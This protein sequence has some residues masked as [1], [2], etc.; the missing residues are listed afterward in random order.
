ML[1]FLNGTG[2]VIKFIVKY[3]KRLIDEVTKRENASK[4][5]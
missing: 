4:F 2:T 1:I 5:K 3:L